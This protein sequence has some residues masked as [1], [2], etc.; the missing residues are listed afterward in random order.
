VTVSV[1]PVDGF[2]GS[3]RCFEEIVD[4]LDAPGTA[5]LTHAEMEDELDR[6]GRDLLRRMF[7]DHLDL[8][9]ARERRLEA[10]VDA[11]GVAH[12]AV[13]AGHHRSLATIFGELEVNRRG[14]RHRSHPNLYPADGVL[15]LPQE[16]HS[17]GLRRLAAIESAR[18]SFDAAG[19]A[20][21]RATGQ[22]FGKRQVEQLAS[23]AAEDIEA[24][25]VPPDQS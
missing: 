11:E 7:Q 1:E 12:T 10:V 9:A 2:D 25:Q 17:H 19:E 14:Y 5:T 21:E 13:E 24:D 4:W 6:R 8:R 22:R 23:R 16:R 20:I 3:R 18:G 15:N